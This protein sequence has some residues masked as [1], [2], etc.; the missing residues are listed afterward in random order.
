MTK[1]ELGKKIREQRKLKKM[2]LD[3]LSCQAG[4]GKVY[5][6]EIERGKKMPSLATF[7]N[8]VNALDISADLLLRDE[9][10]AG[11]GYVLNDLTSKLE[12]LTPRERK[13]ASDI[14]Y[15]YLNNLTKE[16]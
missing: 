11:K 14:L 7:I 6:G 12:A 5:L 13:T 9:V 1:Q 2:T 4:I 8:I 3:Q 10:E 15:A 16:E